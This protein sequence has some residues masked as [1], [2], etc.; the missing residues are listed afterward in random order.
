MSTRI[1]MISDTHSRTPR[2]SQIPNGDVLIHAGDLLQDPQGIKTYQDEIKQLDWIKNASHSF[3]V[4][5]GGNHDSFLGHLYNNPLAPDSAAKK[6]IQDAFSDTN[7][8][9]RYLQDEACEIVVRGHT[10]RV[11]GSPKSLKGNT[12][13]FQHEPGTGGFHSS[14][15]DLNVRCRYSTNISCV[16]IPG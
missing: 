3:K 4:V 2:I 13:A 12:Y 14:L 15:F 10:W 7:H 9:F 11:F 6:A 1:V 5:I 8:G 16:Q